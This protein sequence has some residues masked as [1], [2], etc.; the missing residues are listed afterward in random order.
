M[1]NFSYE[2][3]QLCNIAIVYLNLFNF[4][5]REKVD[6]LF[7]EFDLIKDK[8]KKNIQ[9]PR[10]LFEK[11]GDDSFAKIPKIKRYFKTIEEGFHILFAIKRTYIDNELALKN[12]VKVLSTKTEIDV[13]NKMGKEA[14]VQVLN[15]AYEIVATFSDDIK[16]KD[17][18]TVLKIRQKDMNHRVKYQNNMNTV[19]VSVGKRLINN[20]SNKEIKNGRRLNGNENGDPETPKELMEENQL[21]EE[22]E[23]KRKKEEEEKLINQLDEL[24]QILKSKM[25]DKERLTKR[26]QQLENRLSHLKTNMLHNLACK[27]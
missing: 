6:N 19:N 12:F 14:R 3:K 13:I 17:I 25:M 4:V 8:V 16:Y 26:N 2:S 15:H 1:S 24:Q 10:N 22:M 20:P 9:N 23:V 18:S 11:F 5:E 7:D 27:C 21:D